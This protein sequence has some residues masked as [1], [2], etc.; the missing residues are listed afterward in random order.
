[1]NDDRT[2]RQEKEYTLKAGRKNTGVGLNR[3]VE[4]D[5]WKDRGE[6]FRKKV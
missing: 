1:M 5:I 4:R 2:E 3:H 6:E